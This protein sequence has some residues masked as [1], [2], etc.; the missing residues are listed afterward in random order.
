MSYKDYILMKLKEIIEI[1]DLPDDEL[2]KKHKWL[3]EYD[4]VNYSM[5]CGIVK[6]E[7]DGLIGILEGLQ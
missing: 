7:L 6:A 5:R 3:Q 4:E 2:K 1:V